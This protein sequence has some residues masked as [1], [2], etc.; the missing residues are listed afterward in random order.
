[1][2]ADVETAALQATVHSL[3]NYG[4][5]VASV[6]CDVSVGE[7]IADAALPTFDRQAWNCEMRGCPN[8][9]D[10]MAAQAVEARGSLRPIEINACAPCSLFWFDKSENVRLTPKAAVGVGFDYDISTGLKDAYTRPQVVHNYVRGNIGLLVQPRSAWRLGLIVRPMRL[11]NRTNFDK[12]DEGYDNTIRRYSGDSIYEIR[13]FSSYA[14]KELSRGVEFGVQNFVTSGRF[15]IGTIFSYSYANN[16]IRYNLT[17]PEEV[18]YWQDVSTDFRF[19][20]RY[21]PE[22]MPIV[23]GV[24]ARAM[25]E[26]GWAK[27]PKFDDVLLYDN[28]IKLRSIGAGASYAVGGTGLVLATEYVLNAYKIEADDFGANNF[29]KADITE[30]VGRLGLEYTA[31]NVYSIRGGIEVTDYPIDRWLKLPPNMTRYRFTGGFGYNWHLWNIE[32][33]FGFERSVKDGFDGERRDLSGILWFTR[34][35]I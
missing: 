32:T 27:R 2:M 26:D 23:L 35:E 5:R 16:S 11:Q 25:N 19:L 33:E 8:C 17:F 28:P 3:S 6:L 4:D 13:S 7:A 18:G 24:S 31:L 9:H 20:A 12:T 10:P 34:S 14:L 15:Q 22:G 29:P 30:N 1:M 21:S